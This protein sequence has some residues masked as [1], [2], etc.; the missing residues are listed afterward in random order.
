M[1]ASLM[2]AMI[3]RI[4]VARDH[5]AHRVGP[6]L[7]HLFQKLDAGDARHALVTQNHLNAL[8]LEMH[9]RLVRAAGR[10]HLKIFVERAPDCVLRAH[11]VVH[12][13]HGGQVRQIVHQH[14]VPPCFLM[15]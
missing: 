11:L 4:G 2:P 5:D 3:L 1:P 9:A 8:A 6:A 7:A 10:E 13:Q 15:L 12:H 14:G